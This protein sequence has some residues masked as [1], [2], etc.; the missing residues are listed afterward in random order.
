MITTP[1]SKEDETQAYTENNRIQ[2]CVEYKDNT[3]SN[4]TFSWNI[5]NGRVR[6]LCIN[7]YAVSMVLADLV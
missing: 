4:P 5:Q 2:S 7:P 3:F 1:V 6:I